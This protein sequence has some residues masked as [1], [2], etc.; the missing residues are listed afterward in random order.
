MDSPEAIQSVN[1]TC[2]I[3]RWTGSEVMHR[4]MFE[5]PAIV[6]A[7][8]SFMNVVY[9]MDQIRSSCPTRHREKRVSM[10]FF[11]LVLDLAI[12]NAQ[13]IY[14]KLQFG[15]DYTLTYFKQGICE[16]LVTPLVRMKQNET[17]T[18]EIPYQRPNIDE[19]IGSLDSSHYLMNLKQ[20]AAGRPADAHCYLCLLF[21][22][23]LKTRFGC[24]QCKK[25][26]HPQCATAFHFWHVLTHNKRM[27]IDLAIKGV[28]N[29]RGVN[30]KCKHVGNLRDMEYPFERET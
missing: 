4:S 5:V 14:K 28:D 17:V 30:K 29:I 2:T 26:F 12:I 18:P 8:N 7:Y 11:T 9:R 20:N 25:A 6:G 22:K 24:V 15:T 10:T 1:G 27:M 23:K 16:Q 3:R 13:A 21:Q 19:V